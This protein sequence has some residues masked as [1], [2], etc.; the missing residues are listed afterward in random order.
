MKP[1]PTALLGKRLW[2]QGSIASLQSE[3]TAVCPSLLTTTEVESEGTA[4]RKLR[5]A[6]TWWEGGGLEIGRMRRKEF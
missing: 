5:E 6:R 2:K 3:W 4:S 1:V